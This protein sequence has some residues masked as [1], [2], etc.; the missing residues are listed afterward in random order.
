M[1]WTPYAVGGATRPDSFTRLNPLFAERVYRMTQ[2]AHAAGIPLQIT[3]AY[4]SPELQAELYEK[5]L[6]KYGSDEAARKWVAP[7]GKSQHNHGTAV[8]FA[9]DG[10]LI[11]DADSEAARWIAENAATYGLAVPMGWEPWQVELEGARGGNVTPAGEGN[12]LATYKPRTKQENALMALSMLGGNSP[13]FNQAKNALR[14]S[15]F[16]EN[17]RT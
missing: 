12:A 16:L 10:S 3:S 11:R 7:A 4:R 15:Y 8:D 2:D 14:M 17:E 5:A 1:D 9:V 13:M 6:A